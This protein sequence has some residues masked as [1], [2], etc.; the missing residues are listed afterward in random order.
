MNSDMIIISMTMLRACLSVLE[1]KAL[2]KLLISETRFPI[3]SIHKK[4]S[5]PLGAWIRRFHPPLRPDALFLIS[6]NSEN[7]EINGK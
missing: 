4:K 3:F 5:S 2:F 1:S 7:D 6:W